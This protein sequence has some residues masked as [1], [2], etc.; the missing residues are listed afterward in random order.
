ML[1]R[2]F[3]IFAVALFVAA[4]NNDVE[5][6]LLGRSDISL[7]VKGEL[8]MSFNENTCQLGY[9]S[10]KNEFRVYDDKLANWFVLRC[11][12]SPDTE[13]QVVTADL[14]YTTSNDLKTHKGLE[15][16]VEQVK[17]GGLI[18]LWNE[19]KRIGIVVKAL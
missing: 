18:W 3:Y 19:D 7:T 6:I 10:E 5:E 13:G 17:S 16:S 8:M 4:C 2:F 15:F 9:N 14:E 12:A 11:N 1:K